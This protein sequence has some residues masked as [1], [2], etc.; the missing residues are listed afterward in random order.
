MR[1]KN[2]AKGLVL[3]GDDAP[4]QTSAAWRASKAFARRATE[5]EPRDA[6]VPAATSQPAPSATIPA[7]KEQVAAT[8]DASKSQQRLTGPDVKPDLQSHDF[9][10][11]CPG[12]AQD[13]VLIR[14]P[15]V[16]SLSAT[17]A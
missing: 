1:L 5:K 12:E 17:A 4:C 15:T 14:Q 8:W 9:T 3:D 6:V 11:P 16:T 10:K 7:H 13:R 2:V